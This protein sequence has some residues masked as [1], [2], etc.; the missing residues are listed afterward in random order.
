M[1]FESL[2]VSIISNPDITTLPAAD[3]T[4]VARKVAEV[5]HTY[6]D[7]V[8]V[9]GKN[10]VQQNLRKRVSMLTYEDIFDGVD[11]TYQSATLFDYDIHGNVRTLVQENT[12]PIL[13]TSQNL[14]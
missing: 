9:T 3:V 1:V 11:N 6:Y 13:P 12:N 5:T 14:K 4:K 7:T 2:H 10:I 8:V